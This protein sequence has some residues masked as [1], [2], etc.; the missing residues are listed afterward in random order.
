METLEQ[1]STV[2]LDAVHTVKIIL[3]IVIVRYLYTI[4]GCWGYCKIWLIL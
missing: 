2:A 4:K 1:S 3:C